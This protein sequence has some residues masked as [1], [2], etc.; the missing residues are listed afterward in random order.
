MWGFSKS[1]HEETEAK[2]VY[3]KSILIHLIEMDFYFNN[4]F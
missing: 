3:I 1:K 2:N 4:F